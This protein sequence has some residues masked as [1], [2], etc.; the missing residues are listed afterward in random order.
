MKLLS[1]QIKQGGFAARR[2]RGIIRTKVG[3]ACGGGFKRKI[4][5]NI[6]TDRQTDRHGLSVTEKREP[7]NNDQMREK[8]RNAVRIQRE[9]QTKQTSN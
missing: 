9:K 6:E 7:E 8:L 2:R 4:H 5:I 3:V 1:K